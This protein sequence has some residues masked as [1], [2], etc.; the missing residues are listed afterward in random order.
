MLWIGIAAFPLTNLFMIPLELLA[1]AAGVLFG[2]NRGGLVSL[3]GSLGAAA[4]GYAAGRAVGPSGITRW[5]SGRAY[6]SARQLGARGVMGVLVLR[7]ASVASAGSIHLLCGAGQVPFG[8]YMTG[9]AIGL[10]PAVAALSGLGALVRHAVLYPSLSNGLVAIGAA[11]LL[12]ALA[13]GLRTF[14]LIRQF[15]PSVSN[16]RRRAEFG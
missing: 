14:L 8:V 5:I 12:I 15:A 1:F 10:V 2:A 11:V 9:M 6:R 7:L 13:A 16:Q 4:L 3:L